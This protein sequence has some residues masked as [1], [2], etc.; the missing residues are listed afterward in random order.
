VASDPRGYELTKFR[1]PAMV[2]EKLILEKGFNLYIS[3]P[4]LKTHSMSVVTLGV[5]NQWGF[6]IHADRSPDH[7]YNLHSK[8][9][10]VLSHVRPD[11]TLIEGVEGTIWGHYPALAHADQSVRPFRVLVGGLNVVAVDVVGAR[12]FG[13]RI[14]D[15]PHLALAIERGLGGGVRSEADIAIAGDYSSYD[16]LDVLNEW[17]A[18]GGQYPDD[19]IPE[20]PPDVTVIKGRE[21][22]CR[23]GCVNNSLANLQILT[24][25][26]GGKGGWTLVMGQ[27]FS[28]EVVA[29][30]QGR[31]LVVGPC[32]VKEIGPRLIARLGKGK[33][34]Q[35][36][37]CNDLTAVVESM[38]HLMKVSPFKLA[39]KINPLKGLVL[40]VQSM[41]NGSSGRMAN[42]FANWIKLR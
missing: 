12:I 26:G 22:A 14:A 40:I 16:D 15:V 38:C 33:V 36:H 5:K 28:D 23:E 13:K 10:D 19:L 1:M 2:H 35:S 31:V 42:P 3:I 9:V 17:S 30:I 20:F 21:R 11:V 18:Y 4:K 29:G 27:G 39:P 34:Y 37:E 32:A 7:N 25:D 8:L 24:Y 6:P 41:M